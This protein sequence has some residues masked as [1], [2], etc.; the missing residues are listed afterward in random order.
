KSRTYTIDTGGAPLWGRLPLFHQPSG[1]GQSD[2]LL[3]L[4]LR[5]GFLEL[6]LHALGVG[7]VDAFLQRARNGLDEV[8]RF[9]QAQAREFAN[10]L[11]DADLLVGRVFLEDDRELGLLFGRSG[12]SGGAAS[13]G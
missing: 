10:D 7:L 12:G 5:A 2:Q 8:L 13:G 6:L 4:D 9:L 3:D 11:D 1:E